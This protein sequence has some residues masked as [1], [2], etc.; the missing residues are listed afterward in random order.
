MAG[1][2]FDG[3]ARQLL[4]SAETHLASW[5]PAGRKRGNSWVAGDL[6]GAAGQ[7][8]K[9]NI[10]TGAW[11][12]FATG[13]HGSDLVS[14]YAAIYE[15]PMGE[16]Y[17]ELGGETK[18]ATRMNGHH[19]KPQAQQ[20]PTRR[21][22][23]P[24]PE[25]CADCPCTHP[26]YGAPATRWTYFDGNGEVL[27]YVARYE[28]AGERKQ[29]VPWTWDGERWGMGQWPSPR[30]L[31]GL[32]ELEARPD[33]AVLVVEGE[34][35]ADAARRFATP[36]VVITWPAGAMATDK[37]DWT[38]LTGRKVLLWPDAD[39]PGK[40]AMQRVAQI[41]HERASEVK[42]LEVSDQP[43][44]WDAADAEFTGWADCKAWMTSR[45]SVWAPS[46][47]VPVVQRAAEVIDAETGEI[48]DIS[49]PLPDEYRGRALSTIENLAEICRR[50]GV[51][52]RYNVISK[53]EEIM[54]PEQSFSL[55]NRGNAS[56][57][58]LMS[59][60]ERL[61]M[62]TGKVGDYITYM[63]DRNLHNPVANWIESKPWDGQSRLQDLYDTVASHGDEALKNTIMR[64]WLISA[65]AAAFN[66]NG[67]SAHGVLVFQG[68]QYMGKTAW[69]KRLVPKELGVVQD[70]MM[71]RP[72]DRDSVKQVVSHWL[73][74]LGELD[75]TFRKSDI[76]QLKAFLTRDKDILRRAY[77]RKESEF[78]RR[79]V[80][81]ASVN[82]KEFLH[83][84]TGNRRFWVIECKSIDYDHGIDMQ[85]LWAEVLTLYRAGEP[86]T[87]QGDEHNSLEE[88][89]KTYEVIDPIE[90]L[91]ASGLRWNE[92]PAA[93]RWRSATEVLAE[94]GR[95]TCTQGE[96]TR[97]AHL[98]RQRNGNLSRKANGARALLAPEAWG[99]RNRP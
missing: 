61:R 14:L 95:D 11:A 89:N 26:R 6:S 66:P 12:D 51:T 65:V 43:D 85:Q 81:F 17:R 64:R 19:A 4:A 9:V 97:A 63:A 15:L 59:W 35:A 38:P 36:Y 88:H 57:A 52:V 74:E 40:K 42:V 80:F 87:L 16:A 31:Y 41:I 8:L 1:L 13:D 45:V 69:F 58:W 3:L 32:K 76:A 78:A 29:I 71:L 22:V 60:C 79:T 30:P 2:D 50:L 91:I 49:A 96:A 10:T 70:G 23:T 83:D 62:P 55:D 25:A 86:W 47:S 67:V 54:I 90:E 39:E 7:S 82:P 99:T 72:D 20:E 75:A 46:A 84:Q 73:V 34:K 18:P 27:G 5:L 33:S 28:P 24:V 77:A 92:P 48:T 94:L 56:I 98:I 37:A 21:V 93:W 53:E 44:G 68:A